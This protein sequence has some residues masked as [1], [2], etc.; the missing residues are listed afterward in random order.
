MRAGVRHAGPVL[1]SV[2]GAVIGATALDPCAAYAAD[3]DARFKVITY[4][5][6]LVLP[7]TMFVGYHVHI[8]FEQDEKFLNLG[9]G[10]TSAL[11]V[12]PEGN[13][14]FLKARHAMPTTNL[15]ILTNRHVYFI[16]Y[17]ALARSP[18]PG[19][20]VYSIAFRY[21]TA[22]TVGA[23]G[24]DGRDAGGRVEVARAATE[25]RNYWYCGPPALRPVA[26]MDDGLQLRLSFAPRTALPTIY[27]READGAETLVNTHV[28]RDVLVVHRLAEHLVLRRG[29]SVGCLVDRNHRPTERRAVRGT[30]DDAVERTTREVLP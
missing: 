2:I 8:E 23:E 28:E 15:T 29:G 7:L 30:V 9:A 6:N 10:D 12:G 5:P 24:E 16:D 1:V 4:A 18:R 25:Y 14:L 11:D 22:P 17:Q 3:A 19:E 27:E 13:H 26:A 20:A 21:P